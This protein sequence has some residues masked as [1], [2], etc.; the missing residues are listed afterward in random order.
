[1]ANINVLIKLAEA[2]KMFAANP[3]K[4]TGHND[5]KNYDFFQLED[6]VPSKNDIF[7]SLKLLDL[8]TFDKEKAY[9]QLTDMESEESITFTSPMPNNLKSIQPN[10]IQA[11]GSIETYQRRYLYIT[12]LDV[13]EA[14]P[15]DTFNKK[16]TDSQ[17]QPKVKE[18][19]AENTI[20]SNS[21]NTAVG[22]NTTTPKA[23]TTATATVN[24]VNSSKK[25]ENV[26]SVE[27]DL[28]MVEVTEADINSLPDPEEE[29]KVTEKK[30][31]SSAPSQQQINLNDN[32]AVETKVPAPA[33]K[34]ETHNVEGESLTDILSFNDRFSPD[35]TV[36]ELM[37]KM[38]KDYIIGYKIPI[39]KYKG[40][41]LSDLSY[42]LCNWYAENYHG[43][44]NRLIAVATLLSEVKKGA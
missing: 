42:K 10:E 39:G 24:K 17:A 29:T 37:Q 5:E 44:D 34:K 40:Q 20:K 21:N 35:D 36:E 2:R 27:E 7:Y 6:I 23:N 31:V 43:K 3:P 22:N 14:D 4:K 18:T 9:L 25:E 12:A 32:T 16:E 41:P 28:P 1:M 19:K 30:P 26:V 13:I 15:I 8:V 11:I 33:P 38:D